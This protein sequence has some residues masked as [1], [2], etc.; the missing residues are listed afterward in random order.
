MGDI[1]DNWCD[2]AEQN[3]KLTKALARRAELRK[4][5]KKKYPELM[6][7]LQLEDDIINRRV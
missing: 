1:Y 6:E 7:L 5:C 2:D 4:L 3:R